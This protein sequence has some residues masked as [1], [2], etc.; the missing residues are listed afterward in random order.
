MRKTAIPDTV[1]QGQDMATQ[2]IGLH[3]RVVLREPP[4]YTLTGTVRDVEAGRCLT[5]TN[6]KF[7]KYISARSYAKFASLVFVTGTKEWHPQMRIDATN[8]ADL[9]EIRAD[10]P[11]ATYAPPSAEPVAAPVFSQPPSQ[12]VFVDPAI[13]S[14]GR[15]P[16]SGPLSASPAKV[17]SPA[18]VRPELQAGQPGVLPAIFVGSNGGTHTTRNDLI[19]PVKGPQVDGLEVELE[20]GPVPDAQE[21]QSQKKK[22]RPRQQKQP[23][24]QRAEDDAQAIEGSPATQGGRGKGWRQTPI[25]QSTA[26]FQ[27]FTALKK[28][29]KGR[30]GVLD[31]GWASEDVTEEMG[32][33]DFENNLAKF[34]KRTIFDQMRKEDQVD[35]ASRLVSHNRRPKPGTAGGKN[36]HYTENVL[37][38]SPT[39][40]KNADFW[41]SEADDGLN[42]ADRL[43]GRDVRSS[44]SNRRA[45][46]KSGMSRRSQS[47]K[48]SAVAVAG[49]LPLSRVNSGVRSSHLAQRSISR[50]ESR[51]TN[52]RTQQGH[53]PGLYL[54]PSNRRVEPVSALQ[55]LN[56]ENIAANEIGLSE[57]L[58]TENAG[59]GLAEVAFIALADPAIKVR[60]GLAGANPSASA[61]LSS[62][63]VVLL[64][65]NNKSGTRALAAARHLRNKNVNIIVCLVG[66]ER[67]RDLLEDLR[68]QIQ[69]YRHFGGKIFSKTEFFEHL[70]KNS[71]AGSPVSISLIVDALLGLTISFEELRT[72]DQATVYELMEWANRNEAFVL[73]VDVPTGIDPTSGKIAVIDGGRLFV[74]PRYVVAMGAPKRGLL[75]LTRYAWAIHWRKLL[76]RRPGV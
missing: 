8:I 27:P 19:S 6:G 35:D 57:E 75:I 1:R 32:D 67:E 62:P 71:A 61:M 68:Q 53:P 11:P 47:R 39:V 9:S 46:S 15:R 52:S 54:V 38:M 76:P 22:R 60:F 37:D 59:R 28:S 20:S 2:F 36:L 12:P 41:N 58:M 56:L 65:G 40:N 4:A 13:L 10:E 43:A 70:R 3:M 29:A 14:L 26:S 16:A 33:F 63:A 48:A 30:K 5:L 42:G 69:L 31:N 72:G 17:S 51:S 55:M 49:G 45:D 74:K 73:A 34:D 25:L 18:S 21:P 7:Q 66:I 24:S 44:Q 50:P 64:A 23:K